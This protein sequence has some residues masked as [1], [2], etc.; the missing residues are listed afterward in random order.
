MPERVTRR[1]ARAQL[2]FAER[3]VQLGA[4]ALVGALERPLAQ[5]R[6]LLVRERGHRLASR[7][8][9][10]L[11]GAGRIRLELVVGTFGERETGRLGECAVRT[12][13]AGEAELVVERLADQ[14]VR[15]RVSARALLADQLRPRRLLD[16]G[17]RVL[18]QHRLQH[19]E[20]EFEAGDGGDGEHAA[21]LRSQP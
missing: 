15:E 11:G 14:R 13:A 20:I 5:A 8:E 12:D 3:E 4:Q 6:R 7:G 18:A 10:A 2:R 17:Q 1:L 21:G 19:R 16:R 9:R